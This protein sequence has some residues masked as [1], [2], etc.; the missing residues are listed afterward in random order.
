MQ[1]VAIFLQKNQ[2]Q[3]QRKGFLTSSIN[4]DRTIS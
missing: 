2:K 1:P 3:Q 4:A